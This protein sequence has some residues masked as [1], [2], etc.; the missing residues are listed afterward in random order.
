MMD[1]SSGHGH[2]REGALNIYD[3]LTGKTK[4]KE[5]SKGI[6]DHKNLNKSIHM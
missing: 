2:M 5:K 4:T 3:K 6:L 1:Q